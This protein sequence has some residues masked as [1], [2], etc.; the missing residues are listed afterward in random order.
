MTLFPPVTSEES[1]LVNPSESLDAEES[2]PAGRTGSQSPTSG[3]QESCFRK[4]MHQGR[5]P[6]MKRFSD[7]IRKAIRDSEMSR[8]EIC[9]RA[10]VPQ[11]CLSKF[12]H[13][14]H[15][16]T[17]TLDRIAPVLGLS[18]EVKKTRKGR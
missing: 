7:Q 3:D 13:G 6:F 4:T 17:D 18:V 9:K 12:A 2:R 5:V 15:L 1:P 10:D 16:S 8:Y 11:S 14:Y